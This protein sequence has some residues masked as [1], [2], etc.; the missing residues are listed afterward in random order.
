MTNVT[1][2]ASGGTN[3]YGIW[4]DNSSPTIQGSVITGSGGAFNDGIH[5][6][7]GGT[8]PYTVTINNSQIVGASSTIWTDTGHYT[9]KVGASQLVGT[10][11]KG[12]GSY[13]YICIFSFRGDYTTALTA[14]CQ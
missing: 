4:N 11:G 6:A 14:G 3:N 13:T 8:G 12:S 1:A 9:T 10:V 7:G 2:T 5:N